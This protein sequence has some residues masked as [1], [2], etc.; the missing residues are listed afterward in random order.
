MSEKH[1]TS[2]WRIFKIVFF[3]F[4]KKLGA[5]AIF[6]PLFELCTLVAFFLIQSGSILFSRFFDFFLL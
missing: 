6:F 5:C 3:V 4:F 1:G 2:W